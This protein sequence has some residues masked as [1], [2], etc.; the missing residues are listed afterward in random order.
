[1]DNRYYLLVTITSDKL[2]QITTLETRYTNFTKNHEN[3][4]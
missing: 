2:S 1:M 4:L 3:K